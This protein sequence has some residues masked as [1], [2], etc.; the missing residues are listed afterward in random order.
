MKSKQKKKSVIARENLG[1]VQICRLKSRNRNKNVAKQPGAISGL[2]FFSFLLI[3]ILIIPAAA[4]QLKFNFSPDVNR[5]WVGPDF[6]ANRLEDWR[7]HQGSLACFSPAS[8][9]YLFLL[10]REIEGERG[11]LKISFSVIVPELPERPRA[12]NYIGFRL[13]IKGKTGDF[14]EA[15]VNG[16][17]L[18]VGLT[19]EGLL[20]LGEL[21]SVSSEEKLEALKRALK[22]EIFFILILE[23][24]DGQV[25]LRLTAVEPESG[26]VLD[27]LEDF[28][29]P[30]DKVSGGLA[31]VSCLPEVKPG[32]EVPVSRFKNFWA[33]GSLLQT[34]GERA[35]GPVVFSLYT[36]S[37]KILR[38]NAQLIPGSVKEDARVKLEVQEAGQW[39]EVAQ[40]EVDPNSWIASFEVTDWDYEEDKTFRLEVEAQGSGEDGVPNYMGVIRKE[41]LDKD[42]ILLAVLSNNHEE[43]FPHHR[44]ITEL[45]KHDPDIVFFA[46]NQ[47]YGRPASFWREEF[48]EEQA[49][50]EYLRQWLLFGWAFSELLKDRPVLI[51]ADARDF[52]Q[53][54]L[55]G[56]GGRIISG[57]K[58]ALAMSAQDLGGFLMPMEFIQLVLKTQMW[59]M[60]ER[61]EPSSSGKDAETYFREVNY[62]GLSLAVV[63][64]RIYKSAPANF[65]PEAQIRNGWALNP[66]FELKEQ[67]RV[68]EA[69]LLGPGQLA[70]LR[71]WALDWSSGI[72]MK[73]FLSSSLWVS[74]LTIPEGEV[75]EEALWRLQPIKPGE[76]PAKDRP[77]A[78]FNSGGWP[79]SARDEALKILRQGFAVHIAGSGGPPAALKYGLEKYDEASWAF[80]PPALVSNVPVRWMPQTPRQTAGKEEVKA[81]NFED[82]FGNK[83]RLATV[84]NP[85]EGVNYFPEKGS[86]GFGLVVFEK[87]SRKIIFT[88]YSCAEDAESSN[89]SSY[90]GWPVIVSQLE[91]E[92]RKPAAYLPTLKFK[93][94]VD[95]VVQVVEEKTGE[96]LYTLR[97]SGTEFRPFV[98]KPGNYLVYCGEPGTASWK[99]LKGLGSL[100]ANMKR[101]RL[102][103]FSSGQI[104]H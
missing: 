35:L 59:H 36:L 9:R 95:P 41:P 70:L 44:L 11:F 77:V 97:I 104:K 55:W 21:E 54:K 87:S 80:V 66:E 62:G 39:V 78:D 96:I 65:L 57:E 22:R 15:A 27:E 56:E 46:G 85:Y 61:K 92:G 64:D 94:I 72:W 67:S 19:T 88:C 73:A 89:Q 98:F 8:N 3:T 60:P 69:L 42:R 30:A 58:P 51:L 7:L 50:Q 99:E 100:P 68:K 13:G 32:N 83:F 33:E 18:E 75:G 101:T 52:F 47:V 29:L 49:R 40:S 28:H 93:G 10:T 24:E 1:L 86:S 34:H 90:E 81:G 17:G 79:P 103:D 76:Y 20:F 91:N 4:D 84:S 102:V 43:K 5:H 63:S 71:N 25:H 74:L 23:S 82:A 26:K 31:I 37:H 16:Q 45:K 48:S 53:T 14:R 2:F 6:Y 12:R 38:L